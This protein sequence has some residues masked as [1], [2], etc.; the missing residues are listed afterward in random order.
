[1]S[2]VALVPAAGRGERFGSE[3]PKM[4]LEVAGRPVL[5]WT[6]DRLLDA[7]VEALALAVPE[8]R[9]EE[10]LRLASRRPDS[11]ERVVFTAG[12]ESRQASVAACL[13]ALGGP[14]EDLLVV[15]DGARPAFSRRDFEATI[16]AAGGG[17]GALLGRPISDTLKEL[18]ERRVRATIDRSHLFRAETPQVFRRRD[19][20][21]ALARARADG[22][23]GTDEASLVERLGDVEIA[24]VAARDPNP[25]LTTPGDLP[26]LEWL[27]GGGS[28]AGPAAESA[29]RGVE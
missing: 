16:E 9:L 10:A 26:L 20:E 17:G 28:G 7:G 15:H 19:L 13:D 25:K 14:P 8:E 29:D 4:F 12:G 27:L 23:I 2:L 1:L 3:R 24:A 21:R 5:A 11:W 6:V 18:D 22:F